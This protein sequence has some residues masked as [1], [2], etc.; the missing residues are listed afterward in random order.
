MAQ[1]RVVI[2]ALFLLAAS[3]SFS[4]IDKVTIAAGTPEDRELTTIGSEADAQKR[5]SM[6]EEFLQKYSSNAMAVT[7]ANWSALLISAKHRN[8]DL[9][10]HHRA[11]DERQPTDF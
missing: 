10:S 3:L 8:P 1:I 9:A 4:Q 2:I 7:Y 5:I 11:T 6:Y